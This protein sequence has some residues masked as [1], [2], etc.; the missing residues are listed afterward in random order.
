MFVL[1][2]YGLLVPNSD[3]L[4]HVVYCVTLHYMISSLAA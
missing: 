3:H 1:V 4:Y 2:I